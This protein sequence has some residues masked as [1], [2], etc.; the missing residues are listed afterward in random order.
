MA[1]EGKCNKGP[2]KE[3]KRGGGIKEIELRERKRREKGE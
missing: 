3:K 2:R 1:K